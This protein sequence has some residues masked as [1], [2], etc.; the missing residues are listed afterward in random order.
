MWYR[1]KQSA[2]LFAIVALITAGFTGTAWATDP[3]PD[4]GPN[5]YEATAPTGTWGM[6]P[7]GSSHWH[8]FRYEG[9]NSPIT[10][11]LD[12]EPNNGATFSVWTADQAMRWLKDNKT[13][14]VGRGTPNAFAKSDAFWTGS[15]NTAGTY[16]VR[17]EQLGSQTSYVLLTITGAKV[18]YPAANP[19]GNPAVA[20]TAE[21]AAQTAV[22][23]PVVGF[24]QWMT[25]EGRGEHW[26]A[27]TDKGKGKQIEI[28]L[29]AEPNDAVTFSVW[30][31]EQ[32]QRWAKGEK[33][34]PVG[35]GTVNGYVKSDGFWSGNFNVAGTYYVRIEHSRA[36]SC[37]VEISG[38]DVRY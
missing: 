29:D 13:E 37:K 4:G 5:P 21:V 7:V 27:F 31:G 35:R 10:I 9:G 19:G 1:I 18:W 34:E 25:L 14:P 30:T 6:L 26:Y 28:R 38:K 24:G 36:S 8:A 17:E 15:F 3:V 20:Q 11:T 23:A 33:V 2:R 12:A 16:Y 32:Y 22:T